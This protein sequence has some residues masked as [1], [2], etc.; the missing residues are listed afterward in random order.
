MP[1]KTFLTDHKRSLRLPEGYEPTSADPGIT[2]RHLSHNFI[3]AP[4]QRPANGSS[5]ARFEAGDRI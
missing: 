2:E 5:L 1:K 3:V 4:E